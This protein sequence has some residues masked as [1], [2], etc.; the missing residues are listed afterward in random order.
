MEGTYKEAI[1]ENLVARELP[2]EMNTQWHMWY[3]IH[4]DFMHL[5]NFTE[6]F[7]IKM[8]LLTMLIN[9]PTNI[10]QV[11]ITEYR[12]QLIQSNCIYFDI[13]KGYIEKEVS[14]VNSSGKVFCLDTISIKVRV[15]I[16]YSRWK[17]FYNIG[18]V[19]S[20]IFFIHSSG[21]WKYK[22]RR[23]VPIVKEVKQILK[24][25]K[26]CQCDTSSNL[27]EVTIQ[28]DIMIFVLREILKMIRT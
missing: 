25:R 24:V 3:A 22:I 8:N 27:K 6:P 20:D 21:M 2:F 14:D 18:S 15:N 10:C 26:W 5:S 1:E 4:D 13:I 19:I 16:L 17:F 23:E 11:S 9:M 7:N 28:K 12:I